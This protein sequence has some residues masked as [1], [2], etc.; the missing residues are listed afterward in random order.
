MD[1]A[2]QKWTTCLLGTGLGH[3]DPFSAQV[4]AGPSSG[5]WIR[6]NVVEA[7]AAAELNHW[8]GHYRCVHQLRCIAGFK[9]L[10]TFLSS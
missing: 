3:W 5:D 6:L 7:S 8:T 1:E 4:Q 2:K 9:N 10:Q